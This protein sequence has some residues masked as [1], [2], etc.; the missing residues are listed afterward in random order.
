MSNRSTAETLYD[1]VNTHT[2]TERTILAEAF[3][4]L[5][6]KVQEKYINDGGKMIATVLYD[7][8]VSIPILDFS[9]FLDMIRGLSM[10]LSDGI[11]T[12]KEYRTYIPGLSPIQEDEEKE[13]Q[14]DE[15]AAKY[16][17]V[18][19]DAKREL[20]EGAGTEK[21]PGGNGK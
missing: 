1:F 12:E 13:N 6:I 3:K 21:T 19:D 9:R 4:E 2:I 20:A 14:E 8:D 16:R 10:A 17:S 5:L 18:L 11:I 7:F 15:T